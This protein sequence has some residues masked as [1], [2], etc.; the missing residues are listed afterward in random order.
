MDSVGR[1]DPRQH[2]SVIA[3]PNRLGVLR[4]L[5]AAPATLSQL[6]RSF[7]TYPAWVRHHVLRLQEAGL[8]ELAEVRTTRNYTEKYYRATAPAF[9][10]HALVTPDFGKGRAVVALGSHDLALEALATLVSAGKGGID[11]VPAAI[12]SLDGLVALRQGLADLAGCHLL[13]PETGT[14]NLP[15]VRHLFP[16]RSVVLVTLAERE[17]GMIVPPGNPLGVRG[18]ED[19][20]R[21]D[22]RLANRNGGS[23]T[24]LW[25]D[26]RLREIGIP[27]DAVPGYA[28][29]HATHTEVAE[30][31]L[32]GKA[33][34]GIGIRA[35]ASARELDF[36]PLFEERYDLVVPADHLDDPGIAPLLEALTSGGFRKTLRHLGGY[37]TRHTGDQERLAV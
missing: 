20:G 28:D 3:E 32:A 5:M 2:L 15:Y 4:R 9:S 6:A 18:V 26:R 27:H 11:V 37:A 1:I 10:V 16:E 22:V 25:L 31:V 34:A 12:G 24:R 29:E 23:G 36:L 21:G 35:A 14:F 8:V 30:A 17:Q 33:D 19:L 13:D 7:G